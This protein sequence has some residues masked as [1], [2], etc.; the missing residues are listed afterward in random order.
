M[1]PSV[2]SMTPMEKLVGGRQGDQGFKDLEELM[3]VK[4]RLY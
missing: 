3:E 2:D 4:V 1:T